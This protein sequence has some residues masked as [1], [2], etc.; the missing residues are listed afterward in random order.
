MRSLASPLLREKGPC[1]PL[2]PLQARGPL[3]RSGIDGLSLLKLRE[4]QTSAWHPSG[5]NSEQ[6]QPNSQIPIG[7]PK[8]G[9]RA[10]AG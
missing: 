7:L 8:W 10:A 3:Q 9:A 1:K 2:F 4:T 6:C 5:V